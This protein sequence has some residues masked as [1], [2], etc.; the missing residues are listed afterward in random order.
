ME[1][2]SKEQTERGL[3]VCVRARFKGGGRRMERETKYLGEVLQ[4]LAKQRIVFP[5]PPPDVTCELISA[6]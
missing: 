3:G 6:H 5:A 4:S 1:H 2:C